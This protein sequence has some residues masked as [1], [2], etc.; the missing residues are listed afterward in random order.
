M[1]E[2]K[3]ETIKIPVAEKFGY[4]TMPVDPKDRLPDSEIRLELCEEKD[5]AIIVRTVVFSYLLMSQYHTDRP[6]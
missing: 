5:A 3:A 6:G 2:Y 1:A 4:Q